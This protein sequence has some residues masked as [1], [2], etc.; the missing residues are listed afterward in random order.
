M[1]QFAPDNDNRRRAE[2]ADVPAQGAGGP[3]LSLRHC[4]LLLDIDGTLLELAPTPGAVVVPPGLKDTMAGLLTRTAG[5]FA[6]VSG[7][8][9]NDIDRI[10]APLKFPI[11]G[12][13]GAE[14]RLYPNGDSGLNVPQMNK[15]LKRR[16]AAI[17]A[18]DSAIIIE[19]KGY[20]LA[21]HYRLAPNA[22]RA[23]YDAVSAIRADLPHA[24]FDILPGKSVVE[25]KAPGISKA[26][27]VRE[28][29]KHL[30]FAGRT[31]V[32]LGDDVTDETVFEIM[33]DL[34]GLAYSVGR[35]V[36]G[37]AGHFENPAAV[38]DWLAQL[39]RNKDG[40]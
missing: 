34:K 32:F 27:G 20:S 16:F 21:V 2:T 5:A 11:V 30:P 3:V 12:G 28:L 37:L 26:K 7:R 8:A 18:I 14:F 6:L 9:L 23:I 33:P 31:P 36:S 13:H 15:D 38:R 1:T 17:A 22:E 24:P 19:D 25:F 39:L 10:F 40:D 4:A 29:M 35:E